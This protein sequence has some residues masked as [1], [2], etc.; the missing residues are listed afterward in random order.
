M[1]APPTQVHV[2]NLVTELVKKVF[3]DKSAHEAAPHPTDPS[4]PPMHLGRC[5]TY[6]YYKCVPEY[7]EFMR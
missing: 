7:I 4:V 6:L 5:A 3:P 2:A 1:N